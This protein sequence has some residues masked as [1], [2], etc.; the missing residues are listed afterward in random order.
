LNI[1]KE[2]FLQFSTENPDFIIHCEWKKKNMPLCEAG[3]SVFS[4]S[5][6][7]SVFPCS[8]YPLMVGNIFEER[9]S[10]IYKGK[11]MKDAI[12][13]KVKDLCPDCEYYNFC[14]GNNFTETGDPLKQ[15]TFMA[16]SLKVCYE[17]HLKKG[18]K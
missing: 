1:S 5:A 11:K 2:Q 13:Y 17:E 7:G 3:I 18:G 16:E 12:S 10:A 9:I 6:D 15:P 4:I 8:Q 14:I